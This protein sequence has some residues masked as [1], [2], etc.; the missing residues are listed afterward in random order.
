MKIAGEMT[1]RWSILWRQS[2]RQLP[3]CQAHTPLVEENI[4]NESES[5]L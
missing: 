4:S 5:E 1:G 2:W 3:A